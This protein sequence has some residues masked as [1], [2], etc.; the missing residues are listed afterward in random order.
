MINEIKRMQQ[1]AGIGEIK[2]N[3]PVMFFAESIGTGYEFGVT[4]TFDDEYYLG[5]IDEDEPDIMVLGFYFEG[6]D[7]HGVDEGSTKFVFD[8]LKK[9]LDR[10][11]IPYKAEEDPEVYGWIYIDKKLIKFT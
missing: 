10:I 8:N 11:R 9:N 6:D 7:L 5:T 2:I 1:I 3:S 4:T